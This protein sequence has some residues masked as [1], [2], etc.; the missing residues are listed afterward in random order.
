VPL[1]TDLPEV[2]SVLLEFYG[3][4]MPGAPAGAFDDD[5]NMSARMASLPS[6]SAN[7]QPNNIEECRGQT[8]TEK[9]QTTIVARKRLAHVICS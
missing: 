8:A 3:R 2:V 9:S 4:R 6:G 7:W 1:E 5:L